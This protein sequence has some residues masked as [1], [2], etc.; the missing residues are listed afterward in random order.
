MLSAKQLEQ[1]PK[2]GTIEMRILK[3]LTGAAFALLSLML[4]VPATPASAQGPAYM[5]ALSDLRSARAYLQQDTRREY[6]PAEHDAVVEIDKAIKEIE[7]AATRDGKD[8]WQAPP[9]QSGGDLNAP[10]HTA[11]TLLREAR[12]DLQGGVDRPENMG[13]QMRSIQHVDDAISRLKPY[14]HQ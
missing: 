13:L 1:S 14:I 8:V 3:S 2:K 11:L 6:K 4:L 10:F 12:A 7:K 9:P 5:H